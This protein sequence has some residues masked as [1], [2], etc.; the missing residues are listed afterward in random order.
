MKLA[1]AAL[2]CACLFLIAAFLG[3]GS[4]PGTAPGDPATIVIAGGPAATAP[5]QPV[6]PSA[7]SFVPVGRDVQSVSLAQLVAPVRGSILA[8]GPPEATPL[9]P[10]LSI[11][12]G[13]A[14]STSPAS[15]PPTAPATVALASPVAAPSLA[16]GSLALP[17]LVLPLPTSLPAILS[18]TSTVVLP[19]PSPSPTPNLLSRLLGAL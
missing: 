11:A 5:D 9:T 4:S 10:S 14:V 19:L 8:A 2:G 3:M 18:P 16:P 15:A 7:A 1:A 17:H 12:P 6:A 13:Q